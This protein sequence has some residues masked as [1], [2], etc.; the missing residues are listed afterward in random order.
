M[1]SLERF[2][3]CVPRNPLTCLILVPIAGDKPIYFLRQSLRSITLFPS[4]PFSNFGAPRLASCSSCVPVSGDVRRFT[5]WDGAWFLD[6]LWVFAAQRW[7][8]V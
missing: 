5:Y 3:T 2:D 1:R 7:C 4:C 8:H 6:L